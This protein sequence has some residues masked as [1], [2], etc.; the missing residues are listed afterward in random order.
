MNHVV[1]ALADA[2]EVLVP[3]RG[4]FTHEFGNDREYRQGI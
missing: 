3:I 1:T 4:I 2:V